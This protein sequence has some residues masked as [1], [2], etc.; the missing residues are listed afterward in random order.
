MWSPDSK[1][2]L[3]LLARLAQLAMPAKPAVKWVGYEK[4]E[5]NKN[6]LSI[7]NNERAL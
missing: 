4:G 3:A 1:L 6:P 7:E 5:V 2:G